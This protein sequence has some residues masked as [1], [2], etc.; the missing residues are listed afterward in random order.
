MLKF[1]IEAES[2]G[3][4]SLDGFQDDNDVLVGSLVP[5]LVGT[6]IL[7]VHSLIPLLP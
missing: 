2:L 5:G 3:S 6:T 7:C 1:Y 4:R